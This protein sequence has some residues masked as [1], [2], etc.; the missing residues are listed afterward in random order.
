MLPCRSAHSIA[1]KVEAMNGAR[2]RKRLAKSKSSPTRRFSN[3]QRSF[4]ASRTT[5]VSLVTSNGHAKAANFILSKAGRLRRSS[6]RTPKREILIITSLYLLFSVGLILPGIIFSVFGNRIF[7]LRV[8]GHRVLMQKLSKNLEL[9][10]T[11]RGLLS[12]PKEI[13]SLKNLKLRIFKHK[14][15]KR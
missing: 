9:N 5:M 12:S 2:S 7:S 1:S 8:S 10:H 3:F 6:L 4:C 15:S 11:K 13:F 14:Y